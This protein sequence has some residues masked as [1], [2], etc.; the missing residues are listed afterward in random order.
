MNFENIDLH[1]VL[2]EMCK[3]C[4]SIKMVH[5]SLF[6]LLFLVR[7]TEIKGVKNCLCLFFYFVMFSEIHL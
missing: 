7:L 5:M 6:L 2:V 3:H 4:G 1:K